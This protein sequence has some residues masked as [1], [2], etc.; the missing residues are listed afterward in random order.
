MTRCK[1]ENLAGLLVLTV[2]AGLA[3]LLHLATVAMLLAPLPPDR[4]PTVPSSSRL[5][6]VA[7]RT[8]IDTTLPT[9]ATAQARDSGARARERGNVGSVTVLK[10]FF[11][12]SFRSRRHG[13][14]EVHLVS[15]LVGVRLV[16]S[17]FP[18]RQTRDFVLA[19]KLVA[20]AGEKVVERSI[21]HVPDDLIERMGLCGCPLR[22]VR[23]LARGP[24]GF[25]L[26]LLPADV[27]AR[28]WSA[29]SR[30]RGFTPRLHDGS[31][32]LFGPL[33]DPVTRVAG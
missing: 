23:A 8:V 32:S 6:P 1:S 10:D 31:P 22:L 7:L 27:L 29:A 18:P 14:D 19:R 5:A 11:D 25:K 16:S 30:S 13:L 21:A 17:P 2:A 15:H 24:G 4:S 9:G 33:E 26:V 12:D 3:G 28:I 20:D